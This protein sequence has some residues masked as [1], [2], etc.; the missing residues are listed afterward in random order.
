MMFSIDSSTGA[1][2]GTDC[3]RLVHRQMTGGKGGKGANLESFGNAG[4]A[5][6]VAQRRKPAE[7][8]FWTPIAVRKYS[9]VPRSGRRADLLAIGISLAEI[10]EIPVTAPGAGSAQRLD[11]GRARGPMT[12]EPDMPRLAKEAKNACR[13]ICTTCR[14]T[15]SRGA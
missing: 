5:D 4:L 13:R 12:P 6:D 11:L 14:S 10:A 7:A 3:R 2:T 9:Y 1:A 8:L 15:K